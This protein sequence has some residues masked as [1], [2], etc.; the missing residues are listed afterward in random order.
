[1]SSRR[2]ALTSANM[3]RLP[4][5]GAACGRADA[6]RRQAGSIWGAQKRRARKRE[7]EGREEA[8]RGPSQP[9]SLKKASWPYRDDISWYSTTCSLRSG[10]PAPSPADC[11]HTGRWCP[12][13]TAG[14]ASHL[15]HCG[16][17]LELGGRDERILPDQREAT[18][19]GWWRRHKLCRGLGLPAGCH[20]GT[21]ARP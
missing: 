2:S 7:S 8:D 16:Q 4:R 12:H 13:A 9:N 3:P 18:V 17:P 1:M 20:R 6:Q 10:A 14:G 15:Q 5:G 19:S 21:L 11:K